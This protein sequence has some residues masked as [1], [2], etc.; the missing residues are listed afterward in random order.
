MYLFD[1]TQSD[2]AASILGVA[3]LLIDGKSTQIQASINT[4]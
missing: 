2:T 3:I 4:G 1:F